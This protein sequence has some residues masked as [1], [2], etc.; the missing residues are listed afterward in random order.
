MQPLTFT[1]KEK[2]FKRM[3]SLFRAEEKHQ[4]S[5]GTSLS[6]I[7]KTLLQTKVGLQHSGAPK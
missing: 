1:E 5:R 4:D 7:P 2:H 6:T 3:G